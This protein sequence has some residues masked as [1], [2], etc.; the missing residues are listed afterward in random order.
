MKMRRRMFLIGGGAA[1]VAL[2][3]SLGGTTA[4]LRRMLRDQ[5]GPDVLQLDGIDDFITEF[6]S[7]SGEGSPAKRLAAEM[8]F[9]WHVDRVKMIGPAEALRQ[10]FLYTIL[11]RSNIIAIQ[12]Q[13]ETRFDYGS[14]DPWVPECNVYISAFADETL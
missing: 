12:Q 5:F 1:L 10:R 2:P 6:A 7:L 11:T 8:Y 4:F 9:A 14:V 3:L 13:R